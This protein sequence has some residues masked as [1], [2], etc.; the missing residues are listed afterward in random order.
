[1]LNSYASD[2]VSSV[3]KGKVITTKQFLLALGLHNITGQRKVVEI[4][5]CLGH[6]LDY[7]T[8]CEIETAQALKSQQLAQ[9][10]IALPLVP[11]SEN[12]YVLTILWVDNFDV[13]VERQTS[14]SS[15]NTTH[16]VAFQE[17]DEYTILRNENIS[18]TRSKKRTIQAPAKMPSNNRVNSKSAP[19]LFN[20][21]YDDNVKDANEHRQMVVKIFL[22]LYLRKENSFDQVIPNL[23]GW[24]LKHRND[25]NLSKTIL[26]YLP[27]M[28]NSKVN[29]FDTIITYIDYLKMLG[30]QVNMPYINISL[31]VGAAINAFKM[32]WHYSMKYKNVVIHLGD[33]HSMKENFQ[34]KD[35]SLQCIS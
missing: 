25:D 26:T 13:K 8:T 7:N 3:T 9:N 35:G 4:L 22:W 12:N 15:I 24:L 16:L 29:E 31:N 20:N 21:L 14:S 19:T 10:A 33:F 32:V 6:C 30:E 23:S 34:V 11:S 18:I 27:P 28:I 1:M 5:S 17:K 2:L